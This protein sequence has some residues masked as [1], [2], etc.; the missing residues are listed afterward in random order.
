MSLV[1][2]AVEVGMT[3]VAAAE[4]KGK[5]DTTCDFPLPCPPV[6][7][8]FFLKVKIGASVTSGPNLSTDDPTSI[9]R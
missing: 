1:E 9:S 7:I 2:A 3:I 6:N 5:E 8:F 4:I